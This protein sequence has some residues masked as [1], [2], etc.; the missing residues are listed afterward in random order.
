MKNLILTLFVCATLVSCKTQTASTAVDAVK[1]IEW[2][3]SANL[4]EV[5]KKAQEAGKP[6][7]VDLGAEWCGYCKKM[8]K[9]VFTNDAVSNAMNSGFIPLSLDGEKGDGAALV[10]KLGI[11]GFPTQLILNS[12]GEVIKKNTGYLDT[13]GLLAFLQ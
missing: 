2:A 7:F 3:Q 4:N 13:K 12:N 6:I 1:G 8:K 5:Q 10:N 11:N 9:N